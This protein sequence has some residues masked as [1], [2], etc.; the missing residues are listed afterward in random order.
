MNTININKLFL[1]CRPTGQ[2]RGS[3]LRVNINGLAGQGDP[4]RM[5]LV[6][7]GAIGRWRVGSGQE[8]LKS[9]GSGRVRRF[10]NL[11][12]RVGSG[13]VKRLSKYRGSGRVKWTYEYQ[14]FR[15]SGRV[16]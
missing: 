5:K 1:K 6:S 14:N 9:R 2:I 10:S 4:T 15:G 11:T 13:R 12:G 3:D 16:S 8:V 7:H